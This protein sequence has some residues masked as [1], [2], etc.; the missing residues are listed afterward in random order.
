MS[1]PFASPESFTRYSGGGYTSGVYS[2]GST[3]T[4]SVN[5]SI[6]PYRDNGEGIVPREGGRWLDGLISIDAEAQLYTDNGQNYGDR[7]TY[8]GATFEVFAVN[9]WDHL[10]SISHWECYAQRIDPNTN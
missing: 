3:S 10:A 8:N 2:A 4:V 7:V 9:E 6:Q 1:V 5:C